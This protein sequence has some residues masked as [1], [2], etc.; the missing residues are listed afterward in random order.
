MKK[1]LF[2]KCLNMHED[3]SQTE[4]DV[5][6]A[7]QRDFPWSPHLNM[8][9]LK[10]LKDPVQFEQALNKTALI[11]PDRKSLFNFLRVEVRQ[12][13]SNENIAE[14]SETSEI[15]AKNKL[16]KNIEKIEQFIEE[17]PSIKIDRNYSNLT[18]LSENSTRDNFDI[19]SETLAKIYISQGKKE[20]AIEIFNQ[21]ILK[22]P[23]KSSYFAG[24]IQNLQTNI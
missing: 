5:L 7:M 15:I 17:E 18:D 22:Y 11:V 1:E 4:F 2:Y 24:Q 23:E 6:L 20:K 16:K 19:I 12:E 21:L 13:I 9:A 10:H 8:L 3:I 14:N